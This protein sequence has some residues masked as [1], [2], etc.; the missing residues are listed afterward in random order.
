VRYDYDRLPISFYKVI[1][2]EGHW[3]A[4]ATLRKTDLEVKLSHCTFKTQDE[5]DSFI[6]WFR[7]NHVV[8][9]LHYSDM[10]SSMLY[11]LSGNKSL[12][13]LGVDIHTSKY[14]EEEMCSYTFPAAGPPR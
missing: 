3:R 8:T 12:E 13:K 7:H 14:G 6:E 9:E 2:K 5:E 1:F 10:D 4:L 11:A